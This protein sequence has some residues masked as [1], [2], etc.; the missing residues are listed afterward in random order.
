MMGFPRRGAGANSERSSFCLHFKKKK[1]RM[2][3][4]RRE[5]KINSNMKN[6]EK[7]IRGKTKSCF[8]FDVLDFFVFCFL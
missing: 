5:G 7:N 1:K 4:K 6:G 3:K 2:K 8:V